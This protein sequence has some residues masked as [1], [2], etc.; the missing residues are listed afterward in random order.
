M[1]E[2]GVRRKRAHRQ[3]R[4]LG[5]RREVFLPSLLQIASAHVDSAGAEMHA[6]C[7]Y[8]RARG[9][10]TAEDDGRATANPGGDTLE[11]VSDRCDV[12][13]V[14]D[15]APTLADERVRSAD[16]PRGGVDRVDELEH[17]ALVRDGDVQ[18][19][20]ISPSKRVDVDAEVGLR[21]ADRV[22]AMREP[23]GAER[24][25]VHDRALRVGDR[26][27]EQREAERR[28]RS[29]GSSTRARKLPSWTRTSTA[30]PG[31]TSEAL[32]TARPSFV[33]MA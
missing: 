24:G 29:P 23:E 6:A 9:A 33:A 18:A 10:A 21:A 16:A 8:C 1:L 32:R 2:L 15:H 22:V 27:P 13:V 28:H 11:L 30:S 31:R 7:N 17:R 14:C 19:C 25:F 4:A 3:V 5:E 26:I 12:G 20:E